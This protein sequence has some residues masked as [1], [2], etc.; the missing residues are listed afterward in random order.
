M[1]NNC[2]NH[3]N[4]NI[5]S[6]NLNDIIKTQEKIINQLKRTIQI[7]EKNTF[8]QNKK[9][10]NHDSLLI[11]YNSLLKNYSELERELT[12]A[13]KE[14]IQL[15]N[16]INIKNQRI[17]E[18]QNVFEE[19]KSK[20]ELF[21]RNNDNLQLK[22][23]EL[24]GKLS[25]LPV[26]AQNNSDLNL[27]IGEYENKIK[28]IKDEFNKK[29][30]LFNIKLGNQEKIAK[31]NIRSYEEDMGELN[32]EIR[33]LKNHIEALKRRNDEIIS[34]KKSSDNDFVLKLKTKDKEIEKLTNIISDLKSNINN[35]NLDNQSQIVDYKN[36]I[37]KLKQENSELGLTIDELNSQISELNSTLNQADNYIRQSETE[38]STREN[39]INSLIQEKNLLL[40]QLNEKQ[41]DFSEY[42][43]S[44]EQ[45]MNLLHNKVAALEKEKNF[46]IND[47]QLNRNEINQ[48]HDDINQYLNDDKLHFEE[49]KQADKKYNDLAEA[50]KI[51]EKEYSEALAQLNII[52]NKLKVELELIKSK[53][54]KKIHN[55]TLNNNEL[56][57][58]VKNLINS[59]IALKDYALTIER[60]MNENQNLRQNYSMFIK[61]NNS[62]FINDEF[63][64]SNLNNNV[65]LTYQGDFNNYTFDENN[66]KSRELLNNMKNMINQIDT[67]FNEENFDLLEE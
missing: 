54:E 41:L 63:G 48:L 32:S 52:N 38:I 7:Y 46:L 66:Q 16:I 62:S 61:N 51:K 4:M 3:S 45:E 65:N 43:N 37:E 14:N 60:N 53:Y 26:L 64:N 12:A 39:T 56:N 44:S 9:L 22:I 18:F 55:L 24:E 28:L 59:L 36:I 15:K 21:K 11:D 5:S 10:S 2:L 57:I 35:N 49:C 8:E 20:F 27:K 31:S 50:Y 30:E 23:K 58:R 6:Q 29:E 33:N 42:Q 25:S 19:S 67:K 34:M 17:T 40:K 1:E 13:K 47:N